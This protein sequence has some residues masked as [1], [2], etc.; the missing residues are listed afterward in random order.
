LR[1]DL[2][3]KKSHF[4]KMLDDMIDT[5]TKVG[6]NLNTVQD[7]FKDLAKNFERDEK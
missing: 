1:K 7:S 5:F 6:K 2:N 3:R 4:K